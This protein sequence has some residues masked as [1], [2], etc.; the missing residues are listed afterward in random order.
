MGESET[1]RD[2]ELYYGVY[3]TAYT[4]HPLNITECIQLA[5]YAN[6]EASDRG[7]KFITIQVNPFS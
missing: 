3:K 7:Y 2:R 4:Q 5:R 1:G 6:D